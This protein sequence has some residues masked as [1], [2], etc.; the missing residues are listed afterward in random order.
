MVADA[1]TTSSFHRVAGSTAERG[2]SV[3]ITPESAGW[4]YSGLRVAE[5]ADGERI[6]L[7]TGADEAIVLPLAG[8]FAVESEGATVELAGRRDPF[9]GPTD[10]AYVPPGANAKIESR[11]GGRVAVATARTARRLPVRRGDAESVPVELRGAGAASRLVRNFATPGAFDA[12]RLIAVEVITPGGNWSSYPP[13]KHD[14]AGP[15]ESA[16]EEIYYYEIA[17]APGGSPGVAYQRVY[18]S[19]GHPIDVLV[20]VHDGDVVLIPHGWHGPAMAAPGYDLYYLNVMAGPGDDR[21][22]RIS[23]DPDHAW[24]RGTWADQ[25][26]DPRVE[27]LSRGGRT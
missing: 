13:H 19:P 4:G 12:D 11:Y 3:V 10:F 6:A 20:E 16:L 22:W 14:E 18:G 21:A 17:P 7:G 26:V 9:A 27:A 15:A 23:D 5:L 8:A 1:T 24:V 2:W 25:A